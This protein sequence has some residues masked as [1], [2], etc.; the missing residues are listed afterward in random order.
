MPVDAV[1][2]VIETVIGAFGI[3]G[4][5]VVSFVIFKVPATRTLTNAFI[6]NR[7]FIDFVLAIANANYEPTSPCT[8]TT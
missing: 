1:I 7:A 5:G 8:G 3:L 6:F 4:N 2:I